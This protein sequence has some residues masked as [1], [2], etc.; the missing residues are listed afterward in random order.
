MRRLFTTTAAVL[1]LAAPMLISAP[2]TAAPAQVTIKPGALKRGP[3]VSGAHLDGKT[4]HDGD[5]KVKVN[6]GQV[7]LY[8]KWNQYYVV[9]TGNQQWGNVKLVRVAK[10]GNT[11]LLVA[12]IDP[13]NTTLDSDDGQIAYSYGDSTQKPTIGV[14]DLAEKTEII[15]RSFS[16]LPRL[17]DFD[18][19]RVIASFWN[20]KI[21]TLTWDTVIDTVGKVN[22]KQSNYASVAHNLL[23]FFDKDPQ[24]G[25]CQVLTHLGNKTDVLWTNCNER[26]EDASPD[27]RR[28][29]TIPLLS[30]GIGPA[31][32]MVRKQGGAAVAHYRINGW[33]GRID[34]ETNTKLL[35]ESNGATQSALVR[36]KVA[37]C[38]RASALSPT[39]DL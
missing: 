22:S 24:A 3:D 31:D 5:V 33:F 10:S 7:L 37:E 15:S 32:I 27:G 34:W 35:M 11:K 1:A 17:L 16:S 36:C 20:F 8:G 39:P 13:F 25:G 4:I 29:A 38:N 26:I 19:G 6:A 12:G 2:A 9:A 18:A 23:G 21:K 30:D 14:F 28:F